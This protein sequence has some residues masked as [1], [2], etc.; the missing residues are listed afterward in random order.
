MRAVTRSKQAYGV[1]VKSHERSKSDTE[2]GLFQK[3]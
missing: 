3:F 2:C 1:V